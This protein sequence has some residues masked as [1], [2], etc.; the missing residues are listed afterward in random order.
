MTC[1]VETPYSQI[2]VCYIQ[3]CYPLASKTLKRAERRAVHNFRFFRITIKNICDV[4]KKKYSV[5]AHP[6]VI[7]PL[8]NGIMEAIFTINKVMSIV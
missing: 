7:R 3:C 2:V 1:R 8:N 6:D 5:L 4:I